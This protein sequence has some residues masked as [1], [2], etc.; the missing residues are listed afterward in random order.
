MWIFSQTK[1]VKHMRNI[2]IMGNYT[3]ANCMYIKP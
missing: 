3:M 1:K 2:K